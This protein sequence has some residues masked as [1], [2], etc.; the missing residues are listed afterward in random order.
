MNQ[1]SQI[2]ENNNVSVMFESSLQSYFIFGLCSNPLYF[3]DNEQLLL[4]VCYQV[5]MMPFSPTAIEK[6][7]IEC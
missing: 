2:L 3:Y 7:E 4:K 5:T 1:N 6:Q